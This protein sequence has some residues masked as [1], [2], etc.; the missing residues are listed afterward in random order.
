MFSAIPKYIS[1]IFNNSY[2]VSVN[3]NN[4]GIRKS[5]HLFKLSCVSNSTVSVFGLICNT[6][7]IKI[8]LP[9]ISH[10]RDSIRSW[11]FVRIKVQLV[12]VTGAGSVPGTDGYGRWGWR[13]TLKV[14][15]WCPHSGAILDI[16]VDRSGNI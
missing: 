1:K 9:T 12:Y 5:I 3:K 7:F 8:N 11:A 6:L 14:P 13:L 10:T 15:F 4:S 2:I 16:A